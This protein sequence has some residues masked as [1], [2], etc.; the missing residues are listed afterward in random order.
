MEGSFYLHEVSQEAGLSL[1]YFVLFSSTAAA[2][3]NP[4][5]SNYASAN[6][7]MNALAHYRQSQG[8]PA[9]S[10]NWG[11][12]GEVGMAKDLLDGMAR[13]GFQPISPELGFQALGYA[14]MSEQSELMIAQI[15]WPLYL[16]QLSSPP[17]WLSV[18]IKEQAPTENLVSQLEEVAENER[19]DRLQTIVAGLVKSVVGLLEEQP[20][21]KEKGFVDLGMDSI[22]ATNLRNQLQA[23]VG[24]ALRLPATIAFDYPNVMELCRYLARELDI[25][26]LEKTAIEMPMPEVLVV[27]QDEEIAIIGMSC[28]LPGG[29]NDPDSFWQLLAEGYNGISLVPTN[30]WDANAYYDP[31]RSAPGKMISPLSGFLDIDVAQFDAE[32]FQ[33]SPKEAEMLDPQQR[34]VLE[35]AWE[36]LENAG[37][38]AAGL[39]GHP[40]GVYVGV[41]THDYADMIIAQGD[42]SAINSYYGSGNTGSTFSGRLSY[43]L[44]VNGPCF[45]VDTACSTSLVVLHNACVSLLSGESSIG[46]VSA[47]NLILSPAN[48]VYFTK[49][50]MLADDGHCKTFDAS[51]NGYVRGEG[52]GVLVLKRLSAAKRDGDNVLA[53]IKASGI[54]QDGASSGLTVPN[55]EAQV[56]LLNQVVKKAGISPTDIDYIEAHGTG[57]ALGDPIE[58]RAIGR[59]YGKDRKSD[60][61]LVLGAVKSNV[62]HLE[63]AAGMASIIKVIM[64]FKYEQIPQNLHFKELNPNIHLDFPA[65][66]PT[67]LIDWPRREHPRR[68]AVS[69]FAF[70]GT[71]AHII[72][73]EAPK[74]EPKEKSKGPWVFM[75]SA[76]TD[77]ALEAEKENLKIYLESHPDVHLGDVAYTLQ[78]GRE[79][80]EKRFAVKCHDIPSA[81][82]ALS[83][84][85]EEHDWD[86][87]QEGETI[88]LPTYPFQRQRYWAQVLDKVRKEQEAENIEHWFYHIDWIEKPSLHMIDSSREFEGRSCLMLGKDGDLERSVIETL[89][90]ANIKNKRITPA[91]SFSAKDIDETVTDILFFSDVG[92]SCEALLDCVH[93]ILKSEMTPRLWI[94]TQNAQAIT[95]QEATLH[96]EQSTLL[97]FGKVIA[98][99]YPEFCCVRMDCDVAME[100]SQSA[101]LICSALLSQDKED[102]IAY[103]DNKRYVPRLREYRPQA[104]QAVTISSEHS[105]LITGGLG[106]LGLALVDWFV[107]NGAKHLILT[108]R[109]SP[110]E[111]VQAQLAEYEAQGVRI[112]VLQSDISQ[113]ADVDN[114][115]DSVQKDHPQLKGIIHAAG[116]ADNDFI[117]NQTWQRFS[118]V[119]APKVDGGLHLLESILSTTVDL[120][121][122]VFFSSISGTLGSMTTSSYA[123]A[124]YYLDNLAQ[125]ARRQGIPAM[126]IAWGP[127][128]EVGMA[129]GEEERELSLGYR[130]ISP[131]QGVKAF[132]LALT[133]G[134][135]NQNVVSFHWPTYFANLPYHGRIYSEFETKEEKLAKAELGQKLLTTRIEE[136]NDVI[137]EHIRTLLRGVLGFSEDKAIGDEQGFFDLGMDSLMAV[138][139]RNRL[140]M[141]LGE[142]C[143]L[144]STATFDYPTIAT[145]SEHVKALVYKLKPEITIEAEERIAQAE[146][147]QIEVD[148]ERLMKTMRPEILMS[149]EWIKEFPGKAPTEKRLICFA[150]TGGS[151]LFFTQWRKKLPEKVSLCL[152]N[153]PGRGDRVSEPLILNYESLL[154]GVMQAMM[155]YLDKPYNIFCFSGGA[156]LGYDLVVRLERMQLR[157]P[158]SIIFHAVPSPHY[159]REKDDSFINKIMKADSIGVLEVFKQKFGI[160]AP[161]FGYD[162]E[163]LARIGEVLRAD[164]IAFST[165]PYTKGQKFQ[166]PIT[167]IA[168]RQ[169]ALPIEKLKGWKNFTTAAF[170]FIEVDGEYFEILNKTQKYLDILLKIIS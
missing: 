109:S 125:Y 84:E 114:L 71:N 74:T 68:T 61:P 52:G 43:F 78:T 122:L 164:T 36:A 90:T 143:Q 167:M 38:D 19:Y 88:P 149:K 73:E 100:D 69:G 128:S 28:R 113:K 51:A 117:V 9:L 131:E 91:Q 33:I 102:E 40:V 121:F 170:N 4:G 79:R 96:P 26:T 111:A 29:A 127:W 104:N 138:E 169:D 134:S 168:N 72:I 30:R 162:D 70:S 107:V 14:L 103:R 120:D 27:P 1:D 87:V 41:S 98:L 57:T 76:K 141:S 152:V 82:E 44:G 86:S 153:L 132:E 135:T 144:K 139:L 147:A 20:I 85:S 34:L 17:S 150:N 81:I 59:V 58:V 35:L 75:L 165:R 23:R 66:I 112:A 15:R 95:G 99:E 101:E 11:P 45:T 146:L 21:D 7:F 155:H 3:G 67:E 124:N 37:I 77:E 110:K 18:F 50:G 126:S 6:S 54:N 47:V 53:V 42:L 157:L 5:Q 92:A 140:Q 13:A 118:K 80:F 115:L 32:F 2:L 63:A 108:A 55:G 160:E 129:H 62:G 166:L 97:G 137:R 39:K 116:V 142:V 156:M 64:A 24:N 25:E 65:T 60:Q 56:A 145:L 130:L 106:G 93:A 10:I 158:S 89:T 151:P 123:A 83:G 154:F 161:N 159:I 105:Y 133:D 16:K 48:N 163:K 148:V 31:D 46:I 8:L 49:A 136:S 22:M 119:F 94:I 12:W